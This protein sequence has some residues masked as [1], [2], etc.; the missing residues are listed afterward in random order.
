MTVDEAKSLVGKRIWVRM[1]SDYGEFDTRLKH[2]V[3]VTGVSGEGPSTSLF[4]KPPIPSKMAGPAWD[5]IQV[6]Q[7]AQWGLSAH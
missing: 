6:G 2:E 1:I 7:I 3:T 4:V 5:K